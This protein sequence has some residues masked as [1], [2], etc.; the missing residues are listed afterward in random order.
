MVKV[1]AMSRVQIV[2][3]ESRPQLAAVTTLLRDFVRW[4]RYRYAMDLWFVDAYFESAAWE[5]ELAHLD[6]KYAAPDGALLLALQRGVPA[7]CIAMQRLGSDTCEMKRLFVRPEFH[8]LGIGRQ[9]VQSLLDLAAERGFTTMRLDT[10][11]LQR[12]AQQ[13]YLS[14][15]FHVIPP[16]YECAPEVRAHL[17]FM[18]RSLSRSAGEVGSGPTSAG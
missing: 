1:S 8:G 2:S 7:G 5:D 3:A 11:L 16:Y 14:F 15:G 13:L 18:E 10:G 17:V 12:E 6:Q 4:Q 9:L